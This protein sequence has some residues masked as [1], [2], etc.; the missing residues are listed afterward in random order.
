MVKV[1]I[2]R[3]GAVACAGWPGVQGCQAARAAA[4]LD[5]CAGAGSQAQAALGHSPHVQAEVR[6][7]VYMGRLSHQHCQG[8]FD[9]L[10]LS[11]GPRGSVLPAHAMLTVS[12]R[13]PCAA[14][15]PLNTT[16]LLI[17]TLLYGI[18]QVPQG[19]GAAGDTARLCVQDGGCA[20]GRGSH[21]GGHTAG[22]GKGGATAD[23]SAARQGG[24]TAGCAAHHRVERL[25][26]L[27]LVTMA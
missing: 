26:G 17:Y 11:A 16:N 27:K 3:C 9:I 25:E 4:Q 1:T 6:V 12:V 13:V 23:S 24:L 10:C 20:A 14:V 18:L 21:Q 7:A 5:A 15:V 19:S 2:S 8:L 22:Q